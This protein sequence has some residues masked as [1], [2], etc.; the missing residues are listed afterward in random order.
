MVGVA[1]SQFVRP[2]SGARQGAM[3]RVIYRTLRA[4]F[5]R[6]GFIS[7]PWS[8]L[9]AL[10]QTTYFSPPRVTHCERHQQQ[11]KTKPRSWFNSAHFI[12]F[13]SEQRQSPTKLSISVKTMKFS[14]AISLLMVGTAA[15]F[16]PTSVSH[17]RTSSSVST[18]EDIW[19]GCR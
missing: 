5:Q 1:H 14:S 13:N 7:S 11:T 15:A 8:T 6:Y 3:Q 2:S 18:D 9:R 19:R 17:A 16:A 10:F 4:R 12:N